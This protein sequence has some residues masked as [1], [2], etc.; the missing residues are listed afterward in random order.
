MIRQAIQTARGQAF[1]EELTLAG[2]GGKVALSKRRVWRF[3]RGETFVQQLVKIKHLSV[4]HAAQRLV[5]VSKAWI[6]E[7]HALCQF[8]KDL[9][10]RF[11]FA[12]G[13]NRRATI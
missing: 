12:Q 6:R 5:V 11:G 4:S 2:R 1:A 8:P 7:A 10:I 3:Q 13:L 9:G